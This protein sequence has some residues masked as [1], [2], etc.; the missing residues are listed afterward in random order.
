MILF[1]NSQRQCPMSRA[2]R[3]KCSV[4]SPAP[5]VQSHSRAQSPGIPLYRVKTPYQQFLTFLIL[6]MNIFRSSHLQMFFNI[7]AL[8][9]FKILWIKK[10]LQFRCF[11]VNIAKCLR[12]AF[13]QNFSGGYFCIILKVIK[14]LFRKGYFWRNI[15][16][17]TS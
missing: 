4:E 5:R 11:L 17:V 14:E 13:L 12:T 8:K 16:V 7:G 15:L 6:M 2:Q 1:Y 3:P 9:N 10:S